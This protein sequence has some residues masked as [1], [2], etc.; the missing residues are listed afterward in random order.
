MDVDSIF[1]YFLEWGSMGAFAGWLAWNSIRQQKSE[2]QRVVQFQENIDKARHEYK[3]EVKEIR[4]SSKLEIELIRSRYDDVI[5]GLNDDKTQ[6]RQNVASKVK[7]LERT[8]DGLKSGFDNAM[9][10]VEATHAILKEMRD[11]QKLKDMAKRAMK[12]D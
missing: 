11:E 6:V 7:D 9:V 4:A 12:D 3:E 1:E 5:S 8:V 2:E 10:T